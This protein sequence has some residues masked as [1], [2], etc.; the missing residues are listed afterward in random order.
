M[1]NAFRPSVLALEPRLPLS[2]DPA[3]SIVPGPTDPTFEPFSGSP[4]GPDEPL[5]YVMSSG[6]SFVGP[7]DFAAPPPV[8]TSI[9]YGC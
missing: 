2:G 1:S 7:P 5:P 3:T 9:D 8:S 6:D 4:N